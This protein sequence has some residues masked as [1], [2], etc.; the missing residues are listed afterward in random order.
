MLFNFSRYFRSTIIV[1]LTFRHRFAASALLLLGLVGDVSTTPTV[2]LMVGDEL[3]EH[4]S[5]DAQRTK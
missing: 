1:L 4:Y 3:E 5:A 2:D